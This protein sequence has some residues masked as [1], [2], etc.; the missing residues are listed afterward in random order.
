MSLKATNNVE[1]NKYELEIEI[2]AED[3]EAAIEKA[4]LKARKNIAMPGFRKGK[5]PRKLIEKEYGEQVFF[6]DAV[7]LLYAPVV[8]GAVEESG[9]ELVTRPEVEVTEIS[10]ENGV[11]LKATCITKPEVEV[12]DYKGI[13]VEKVVNPVTDEDINKQLDALRE[14]NVTVETVDD[15]AAENG[16]DVV[17]DFEGFKDDVAFEGGKAEDFTLSLGSGQFI[18][19]FEDQI[20]GHNA[21]E[22]FDINVTFPEEYQVKELAGAPAVFK[23]KLKSIS[24][25][26]MPEL[27]DDMVKDSTEFDTVDEYKADVKKK[28]EEAN[29]KHADSE[30]EAKIFDKVIENM[31]AE[32]PQVMFDNRVNEMVSELEQRLAPQGISLDLYMQ[33]TGQTMDTVKKAY[34]EQAEKQVKLRLALEKI[35]KLENIEVTEDELKA[36]FDKLAE[37]Y[38]LDVDQI[39]Q[40]I[41]DDD[42]KKDIAVGKAVDLIKDAAVI[43]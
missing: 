22:E 27:D 35:A 23:I 13:E 3:F 39:K 14:K 7:N 25:K 31:T 30:V 12:K 41:H 21:G 17:I 24:K 20:V 36:E 5:A 1:T 28:L 18:P 34:A 2:S 10:K 16:D 42:L 15:R 40:F 4:Y 8:N 38:K 9:L 29:E 6:E 37:A 43:K 26:V 11:K 33:Y 19:G 32:I